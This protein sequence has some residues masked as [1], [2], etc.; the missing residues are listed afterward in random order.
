MQWSWVDTEYSID[1][2]QHAPSTARPKYS[3]D[4]VQYTLT[5]A[6]T[7]YSTPQV[8]YPLKIVCLPFILIIMNWP[9]NGA[10]ASSVPPYMIDRH[11]PALHESSKVELTNWWIDSQPPVRRPSTASKDLSNITRSRPPCVSPNLL[12]QGDEVHLQTCSITASKCISNLARSWPPSV[13]PDSLSYGLQV[14]MINASRVDLQTRLIMASKFARSWSAGAHAP[15]RSIIASKC[16]S[17]LF[18]SLPPVVFSSSLDYGL[19]VRTIMASKVHLRTRLI[20]ASMFARSWPPSASP[21]LHDHYLGV[22]L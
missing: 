2:V 11:Q 8:Q 7:E 13:S 3:I 9:L 16:I 21:N 6:Y 18:R 14:C 10:S 4:R 15:T 17:K 19:R 12:N 5:T 22:H 20:M 1:R